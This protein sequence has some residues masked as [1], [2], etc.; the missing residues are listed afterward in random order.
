MDRRTFIKN[1]LTTIS[2]AMML[3]EFAKATNDF[4][5][6]D[7]KMPVLFIG[8]G[9]PMNAIEEND[10]TKGWKTAA[11]KLPPPKAILC[12]SA[13]WLTNGTFVTAMQHPRT[14][15]DFYGFPEKLFQQEY[16]APGSP[17]FANETKEIIKK[18]NV[19]LDHEWGLDHGTWSVLLP[20]YPLA[21]IPVYQ[22]SIDYSKPA[23][24][25]YELAKELSALRKKGVLIIGS[26]NIVHNLGMVQWSDKAFDWAIEF[27]EK[28]KQLIL[29]KDHNSII[30]YEKL[31]AAA[32]LSIPTNDHYL[33]LIYSLALQHEKDEISF[34]NETTTMGSISMRSVKFG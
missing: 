14:I 2:S 9:N 30:N 23:Q 3:S 22:L 1:T 21:K 16:P 28:I 7:S 19:G 31:G 5:E 11:S 24:Y 10:F 18:T 29:K 4:K 27:D 8:H 32:K 25:H 17:D 20:M 13:H 12:I 15:H 26:G 34:F 33:P 6:Q